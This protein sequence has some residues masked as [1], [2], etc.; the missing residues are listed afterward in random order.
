M[1]GDS[2]ECGG[3]FAVHFHKSNLA[4]VTGG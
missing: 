4:K 1:G 2:F 3:G